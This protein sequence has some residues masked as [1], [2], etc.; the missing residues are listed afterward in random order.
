MRSLVAL[1]F[2]VA[3]FALPAFADQTRIAFGSCFKQ[4][5]TRAGE[6]LSHQDFWDPIMATDP[7]AFLFLGDNVY[8]DRTGGPP[9]F[10]ESYD[11]LQES[12]GYRRLNAATRVLATWDDHDFGQN[13]GGRDFDGK[14]EAEAIFEVVFAAADPARDSRPGVYDSWV[15]GAPGKRVQVILLD[16]RSFRSPL[17]KGDNPP[18][19]LGRYVPSTDPDQ[20]MLGEAQWAWLAEKLR[21]PAD[22]RLIASSIQVLA[23][24]HGWERWGNLPK[25]QDRLFALLQE[26]EA[27]GVILLSGDRHRAGLYRHADAIG[28]PLYEITS[29]SLNLSFPPRRPET[30]PHLMEPMFGGDNFGLVT[31]DW[32][33]R[34]VTLDIKALDGGTA[35]S[36]TVPLAEL[37]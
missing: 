20:A 14:S 8:A 16:T 30:G 18:N 35:Q 9:Q 21:E 6:S 24:G 2:L 23:E 33:A 13:D 15:T 22:V 29:S 25:E 10:I 4:Q 17:T 37:R 7:A 3:G 26:T 12:D 1:C 11:V 31:V 36:V 34:S 32:D 28:Y 27:E 19:G 5:P